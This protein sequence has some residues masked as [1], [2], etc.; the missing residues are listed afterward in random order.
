LPRT[1]TVAIF[2]N[3]GTVNFDYIYGMAIQDWQYKLEYIYNIYD[4]QYG[5]NIL[6]FNFGEKIFN[7]NEKQ[8]GTF[9]GWGRTEDFGKIA[10]EIRKV[11]FK[12]KEPSFPIA[13]SAGINN[14]VE[15][16]GY[17]QDNFGSEC[18]V[19]NNSGFY[20][21]L[22]GGGN[23]FAVYGYSISKSSDLE[24]V[25]KKLNEYTEEET[26]YFDTNWIQYEK[27]IVDLAEW[28][29][30][31]WAKKSYIIDMQV[32]GAAL[33]SVGDVVTISYPY[34][35]ITNSQKFVVQ[36]VSHSFEGGLTTNIKCRTI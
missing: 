26:V 12:F 21:L 29:K 34:L 4:G 15:I 11:E 20:N 32:F 23:Q 8:S 1:K 18:Y 7:K 13:P 28:L 25:D 31:E 3:I 16:L 9:Q 19:L 35:G 36:N 14:F 6:D 33:I 24:Y 2:S 27:N 17:R 30:T 22:S 5:K 10:R